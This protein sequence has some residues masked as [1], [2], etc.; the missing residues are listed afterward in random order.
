MCLRLWRW[1]LC[2]RSYEAIPSSSECLNEDGCFR[3]FAQRIAQSLDGCIKAM[4]KIDKGI[5]GPEPIANFF[6]RN[7]LAGTLQKQT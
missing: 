1:I 7:Q 5:R 3:R 2:D 4:I 6:T